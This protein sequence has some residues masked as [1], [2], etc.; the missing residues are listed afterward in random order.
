L[1]EQESRRLEPELRRNYTGWIALAIIF[2]FL[3]IVAFRR[4]T[5]T[6]PNR[7]NYSQQQTALQTAVRQKELAGA[8]AGSTSEA[9]GEVATAME[10]RKGDPRAARLAAAARFEQGKPVSR[11]VIETLR[12][13]ATPPHRILA[14]VYAAEKLPPDRARGIAKTIP[15][16]TFMDRLARAHTLQKGGV[17][18]ARAELSSPGARQRLIV[19]ALLIIG[20]FMASFLVWIV[21][22]VRKVAKELP[23]LGAPIMPLT[24]GEA[25]RAA[26]VAALVIGAFFIFS[27]LFGIVGGAAGSVAAGVATLATIYWI[28]QRPIAGVRFSLERSG[29]SRENLGRNIGLGILGFVAELPLTFAMGALGAYVF[30]SLPPPEHPASTALQNTTSLAVIVPVIIAGSIMAPIWEEYVFRG[31][32]FPAI[33]RAVKSVAFGAIL[34]SFLFAAIHPQGPVI[35]GALATV[36]VVS[37]ALS[38]HTKSLVPS[39]VLHALHNTT[40]FV[41]GLLISR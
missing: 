20:I 16:E 18:G 28:S 35:V 5:S 4:S 32:L 1:G 2:S 41:L 8:F 10:A 21:V 27:T 15:G 3:I 24:A 6:D 7:P 34:S 31:M 29:I 30:R 9:F 37:A 11:E 36:A 17:E 13:S 19:A 40:L 23:P 14:G 12:K 26:M 33:S 39:I 38:Y 22:I 25:D